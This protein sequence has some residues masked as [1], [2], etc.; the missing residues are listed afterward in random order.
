MKDNW[1]HGEVVETQRRDDLELIL[2]RE[3]EPFDDAIAKYAGHSNYDGHSDLLKL[4]IATA[5][6]HI[7]EG[8]LLVYKRWNSNSYILLRGIKLPLGESYAYDNNAV[9][10]SNF[11]PISENALELIRELEHGNHRFNK[12]EG[13][14]VS[15]DI[16]KFDGEKLTSDAIE[17]AIQADLDE[18]IAEVK[19]EEKERAA[20]A[21]ERQEAQA[22]WE[23]SGIGGLV[24]KNTLTDEDGVVSIT[25]PNAWMDISETAYAIRSPT[26]AINTLQDHGYEGKLTIKIKDGVRD[27]TFNA[28]I[29]PRN[30]YIN[31]TKLQKA[32]MFPLLRKIVLGVISAENIPAYSK[33]NA[34][35][36]DVAGMTTIHMSLPR[37]TDY[38]S[39]V[40]IP[41]KIVFKTPDIVEIQLFGETITAKWKEVRPLLVHG[42]NA[43]YSMTS[44]E[45]K[46]GCSLTSGEFKKWLNLLGVPYGRG[47]TLL[48][49]YLLAGEM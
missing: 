41:I 27:E 38:N 33:L 39:D 43:A 16:D 37:Q 18:H 6:R 23:S 30:S 13:F 3:I 20:K 9:D 36:Q 31:S 21:K 4:N 29:E 34:L 28:N 44:G 26:R 7:D 10:S 11:L 49:G 42:K 25:L 15:Y 24:N 45:F 47:L 46:N 17:K 48:R 2:L 5:F 12:Q 1:I 14:Y 32:K 35:K 8:T 19:Q 22:L 40:S